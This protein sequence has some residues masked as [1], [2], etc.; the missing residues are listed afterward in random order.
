MF[1]EKKTKSARSITF[2]PFGF[3]PIVNAYMF[4]TVLFLVGLAVI[5]VIADQTRGELATALAKKMMDFVEV[6][7]GATF[8]A[9]SVASLSPKKD[10][11][12]QP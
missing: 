5:T 6:V 2:R 1:E 11:A 3:P 12:K 9:L 10:S 8:G 4:L 7:L